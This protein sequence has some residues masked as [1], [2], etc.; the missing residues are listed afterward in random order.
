MTQQPA[1]L[2][3]AKT[4][5]E[6]AEQHHSAIEDVPL[7]VALLDLNRRYL[8]VNHALCEMLGYSQEELLT[9]STFDITHPK[10]LE[11]SAEAIRQIVEGGSE[12]VDLEKRYI[13][14]DGHEVWA[15][16]SVSL[17]RGPE[18][19]HYMVSL[20]QDVTKRKALEERLEHLAYH[21]A[22][23]G[24]TNR[25]LLMDRIKQ[26]MARLHPNRGNLIMLFM[27]LD[28]FKA[29][30]DSLGHEAGDRL[31]VEAAQR[32]KECVR[33][34]DTVA[35]FGGD[36]F[37]ILLKDASDLDDATH[38]AE[39]I[40]EVLSAPFCF[41]GRE[42]FIGASVGIASAEPSEEP[43]DLLRNADLALYKAK[44]RGRAQ[45]EIFNASMGAEA[46]A[47][48]ELESDL[49]GAVEREEFEV[50]YQPIVDLYTNKI[51]SLEALVRWRHPKR[52]LVASEEFIQIAEDTGLIRSIG[53]EVIREACMQAKKWCE[54]YPD[55]TFLLSVN[56]TGNQL[57]Y[58]ANAIPKILEETG[59]DPH[60]LRVELTERAVMDDAEFALGEMRK[61]EALGISFAVDDFGIGYSCLYYLKRMPLRSLKIDRLFVASLGTSSDEGNSSDAAIVSGTISLAH[62]LGLEVVAE[63]VETEE[64]LRRLREM[65]CDLAQGYY[66]AEPLPSEEVERVLASPGQ[67]KTSF[68]ET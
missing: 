27:D 19:N 49:R 24:L 13:H 59:F 37:A 55:S 61:L 33:C 67:T 44:S 46:L 5:P 32:L 65:G 28:N 12:S 39:R 68:R 62:D 34:E 8:R 18:E 26:S 22:L 58:Q 31:L 1:S 40:V 23:T 48:M 4:L 60:N 57:N 7:G 29:V 56:F 45:C 10:D 51:V 64:Q 20:V 6:S 11:R 16:L 36:E 25:S 30:N 21:D 15:Q 54:Q 14:A 41:D 9:K 38:I 66:Y 35:R 50:H 17:V 3:E 43:E 42:V 2:E 47:R 63:G 53:P 52:G